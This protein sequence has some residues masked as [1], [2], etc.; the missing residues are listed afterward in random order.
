M[1]ET[2]SLTSR[3][4]QARGVDHSRPQTQPRSRWAM[5]LATKRPSADLGQL[6]GAQAKSRRN[7]SVREL[8]AKVRDA[9][10]VA[11]DRVCS[12]PPFGFI[13]AQKN[14]RTLR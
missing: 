10:E 11:L 6:R 9:A 3:E 5:M 13:E 14:G 8:L 4:G 2:Y 7:S 12:P 1:I